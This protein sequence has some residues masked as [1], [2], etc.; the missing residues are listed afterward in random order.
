MNVSFTSEA[1]AAFCEWSTIDRRIFQKIKD[2]II[3][4]C[5]DPFK[6]TG[7]PEPLKHDLSGYWS[8]RIT[9][10]HRL[11]YSVA[12]DMIRIISCNYH[13]TKK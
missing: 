2:L 8:R 7:K 5:R 1:F 9:E 12:D 10:E 4:T 6:G 11:V 13:Y 3:A